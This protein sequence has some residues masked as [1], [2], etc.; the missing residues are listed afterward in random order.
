[1]FSDAAALRHIP[2]CKGVMAKPK[3]LDDRHMGKDFNINVCANAIFIGQTQL[4]TIASN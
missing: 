4:N 3:K 1:M 2:I